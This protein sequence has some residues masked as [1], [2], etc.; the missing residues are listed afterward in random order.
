MTANKAGP[1]QFKSRT[2]IESLLPL[3]YSFTRVN[4]YFFNHEYY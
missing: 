1:I 2:S 3:M 4:K